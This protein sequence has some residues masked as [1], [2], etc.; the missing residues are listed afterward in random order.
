MRTQFSC[1]RGSSLLL[2]MW[3]LLLLTAATFGWVAWLQTRLLTPGEGTRA[4]EA[5]FM[6]HSGVTVALHPQ[7][8][9]HTPLPPEELMPGAGYEL[10]IQSEGGKLNLNW[11]MRGEEPLKIAMFKQWLQRRGLDLHQQETFIDC[12]L[13][14]IDAD[15]IKRLN[16]AEDD[17]TYHPANRE[18]R[19]VEELAQVKGTDP[20]TSQPGWQDELTIYSQGPIDLTSADEEVLAL[21]PGLGDARIQAFLK[22]RR[23][24]DGLDGTPDD[25][26]FKDVAALQA[27][28]GLSAAQFE[29]LSPLVMVG[30]PTM[31]IRSIGHSGTTIREVDVV[32]RKGAGQPLI[33][34]WKEGNNPTILSTISRPKRKGG[35]SGAAPSACTLRRSWPMPRVCCRRA[36]D[37]SLPCRAIP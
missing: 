14:Y 3:A 27:A 34:H 18:L 15:N 19:S 37:L 17:G 2:V 7:V 24:P 25:A 22:L 8:T 16:G 26:T 4:M 20:L 1:R 5:L 29:Q 6:A 30:D 9:L 33:L 13:D 28:L 23:G 11:L 10:R 32:A 31:H 21:L 35:P 36:A 12:L